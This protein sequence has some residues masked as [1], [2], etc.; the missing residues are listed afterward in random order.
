[1]SEK[2]VSEL[3]TDP[4]TPKARHGVVE[5]KDPPEAALELTADAAEITGLRLVDAAD[6]A[7]KR[8]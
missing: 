1:M 6:R 5:I 4:L 2:P 8:D 7:R 3:I